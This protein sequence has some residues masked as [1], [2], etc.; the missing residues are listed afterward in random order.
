L[1]GLMHDIGYAVF[2]GDDEG[3]KDNVIL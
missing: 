3:L 2:Y 1:V